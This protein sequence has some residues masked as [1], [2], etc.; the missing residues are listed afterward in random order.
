M[1]LSLKHQILNNVDSIGVVDSKIDTAIADTTIALTAQGVRISDVEQGLTNE[2]SRATGKEQILEQQL[3]NAEVAILENRRFAIFCETF[4]YDGL[5][6]TNTYPFSCGSGLQD[7]GT[8]FGLYIPYRFKLIGISL[9]SKDT[10]LPAEPR[11]GQSLELVVQSN[12]PG[13]GII[14]S[15]NYVATR[16]YNYTLNNYFTNTADSFE[17][18]VGVLS[19]KVG[20]LTTGGDAQPTIGDL[21]SK[22]RVSLFLQRLSDV[23]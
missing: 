2:I 5:L 21:H 1:E 15:N 6:T 9:Q 10:V 8:D 4:E 11:E 7:S 17:S 20:L 22:Y 12:A 13:G 23:D 16:P 19:I 3:G 14:T 18:A